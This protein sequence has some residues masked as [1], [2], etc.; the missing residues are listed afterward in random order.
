VSLPSVKRV[1]KRH[2]QSRFSK[3]KKWHQ[4]PERPLPV[5]PG[6]LVEI[7][8]IHEGAHGNRLYIYTLLDVCSRWSYAWPTARITSWASVRFVRSAQAAAP[9]PF[10]TLQSDHGPEFSKWFTKVAEHAG[11][12]HRHSR[13]RRPTDNGHLERFNR[14][15]QQE[16]L[17][18]VPRSL[19]SWQKEIP[20]YLRYYNTERPHMGLNMRTPMEVVTSY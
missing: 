5:K 6:L 1:L 7:D 15:I 10:S 4:Y 14:T 20:E 19:K 11:F 13:V 12:T 16:R 18:R 8:T 3:W 17:R 9:F 2:G